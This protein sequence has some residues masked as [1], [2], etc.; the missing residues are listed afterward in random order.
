MQCIAT[1]RKGRKP[2]Q[3]TFRLYLLHSFIL[4]LKDLSFILKL[5]LYLLCTAHLLYCSGSLFALQSVCWQDV[6][7]ALKV[8]DSNSQKSPPSPSLRN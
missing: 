7:T 3:V 2:Q 8:L 6:E 4:V 1:H 5:T